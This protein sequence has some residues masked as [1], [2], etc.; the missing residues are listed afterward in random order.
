MKVAELPSTEKGYT[1]QFEDSQNSDVPSS[2]SVQPPHDRMPC[3][4]ELRV[5]Q[6]PSVL[7]GVG[8]KGKERS[9]VLSQQGQGITGCSQLQMS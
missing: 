3:R 5:T 9:C 8:E 7:L 6:G 1:E 2:F 4:M